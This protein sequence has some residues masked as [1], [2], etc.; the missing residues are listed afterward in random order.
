MQKCINI[1]LWSPPTFAYCEVLLGV[2][3]RVRAAAILHY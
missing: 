3:G 2:S 1:S